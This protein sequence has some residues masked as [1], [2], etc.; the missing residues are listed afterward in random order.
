MPTWHPHTLVTFGGIL[1]T[2][3]AD[4]EIWQCGVRVINKVGSP[5]PL[6]DHDAY[7]TFVAPALATW[8]GG[9]TIAQFP[10]TAT[11]NWVKA[12]PIAADGTYADATTHIHDYATPQA[13]HNTAG[14]YMP[15]ILC[16]ALS[17]QTSKAV[18]KHAYATHGRIYPPNYVPLG[19]LTSSMRTDAGQSSVWSQMGAALLDVLSAVANPSIP[20]IASSHN[21]EYSPIIGCRVGNVIDV[22]RRRKS[23][24]KEAYAATAFS[25]G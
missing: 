17:W 14:P 20:I 4:H 13:G 23:A 11:L 3:A 18:R 25:S 22:Q 10:A 19:A 24:L 5:G 15:D 6:E 12:N 1:N 9:N 2:A 7:L 16:L 21:G 8:Y